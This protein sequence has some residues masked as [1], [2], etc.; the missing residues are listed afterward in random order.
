VSRHLRV[1]RQAGLVEEGRSRQDA[2]VRIYQLRGEQ[3]ERVGRFADE[4]RQ[5]AKT[6]LA[7]FKQYAEGR[8]GD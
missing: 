8:K 3:V 2:R 4:L 7:A 5:F 6:Q 1:L